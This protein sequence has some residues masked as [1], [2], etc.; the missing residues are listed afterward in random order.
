[1]VF[2][3]GIELEDRFLRHG[4]V[5]FFGLRVLRCVRISPAPAVGFTCGP[6]HRNVAT[7]D[8]IDATIRYHS[9]S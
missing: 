9:S 6:G 3:V 2:A 1:M 5:L 4:L 8:Q 7:V